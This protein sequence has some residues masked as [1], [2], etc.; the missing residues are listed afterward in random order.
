M[1]E[2]QWK[3]FIILAVTSIVMVIAAIIALTLMNDALINS[4]QIQQNS[5]IE[6]VETEGPPSGNW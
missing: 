6:T 5:N 1:D 4:N 3:R 2:L